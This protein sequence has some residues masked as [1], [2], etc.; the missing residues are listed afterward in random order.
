FQR[1]GDRRRD[2]P[3]RQLPVTFDPEVAKGRDDVVLAHLNHPLVAM[4][5]RLPRAA[6]SN[7]QIGLRRVTAVVSDDPALEGVLVG[8]YSRFVLVGADGVRLHEEVLYAGG[9][10]PEVGRFRRLENL[11]VLGGILD[12]ALTSGMP[13]SDPVWQRITSRWPRISDGLLTA[14]DW[15]TNTRLESL[16][17]KLEQREEEERKRI[18]SAIEQ[19]S[20]TLRSA[21]AH[22]A[23]DEETALFSVADVEKTKDERAQYRRDRQAWEV[24]LATLATERDRELEAIA[25]RY[26]QQEPHRFPVAVVFVVPKREAT[27]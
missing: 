10:A 16:R 6:V 15:R 27:R 24:R 22:D 25:A 8:A 14:I 18:T 2:E 12:R 7:E 19:F 23:D 3:P 5:T 4:S 20:A 9:W 17:R 26:R 11:T 1:D 21:L 13:V